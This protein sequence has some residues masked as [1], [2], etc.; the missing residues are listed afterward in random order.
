MQFGEMPYFFNTPH[1]F[2]KIGEMQPGEMQFGEMPHTHK[3]L[4]KFSL[5]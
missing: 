3:K 4:K 1:V 5:L 2:K